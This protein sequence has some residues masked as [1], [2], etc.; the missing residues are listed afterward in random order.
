MQNLLSLVRDYYAKKYQKSVGL[1]PFHKSSCK[2]RICSNRR[3]TDQNISQK[4][5]TYNAIK[6]HSHVINSSKNF[7]ARK[8]KQFPQYSAY[9]TALSV[10]LCRGE[11]NK[12]EMQRA[13]KTCSTKTWASSHKNVQKRTIHTYT[14]LS[15]FVFLLT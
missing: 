4:S 10:G 8:L 3:P 6:H 9:F 2:D 15:F 1:F 12:Q 5:L 7:C 11:I 13:R 14:F